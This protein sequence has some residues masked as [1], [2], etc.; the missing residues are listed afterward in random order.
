MR[1]E[2]QEL[3]WGVSHMRGI[4]YGLAFSAVCWTVIGVVVS[5]VI[6]AG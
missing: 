2:A 6:N 3:S 4:F 5:A 1:N